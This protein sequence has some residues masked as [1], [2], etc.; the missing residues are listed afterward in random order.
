MRKIIRQ[1]LFGASL[2]SFGLG[3]ST[4]M[5]SSAP[6]LADQ[7]RNGRYRQT[8]LVSDQ[9][10][11][12]LLQDTNLVN[13]W[14]VSFGPSSPF[15]VSDNGTGLST[16]YIVT[17]D[18][19]GMTH[20]IK[21]PLQVRIPGEGTPTGQLFNGNTNSFHGNLFIFASEDGIISG[22]RPQ[23][24]T[25]AEVLVARS[26]AVYKGITMAAG[27]HG[28]VLLAANF[29]EA[30]IDEYDANLHLIGQFS[31]SM[32]PADYGPFNVQNLHG[33]VFVTY[34][35]QDAD[36]QDDVAGPGNGLIDVFDPGT[37]M[38]DRFATGL[39]AGGN[40]R[41]INSPWGLALAPSTFGDHADELLVGNFGSGT[42]MTFEADGRFQGLLRGE[43][44]RPVVIDGLWAL[45]FGNGTQAGSPDT[46]FFSAGPDDESHGLFGEL[47]PMNDH[48]AAPQD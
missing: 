12:A 32:A 46:L 47:Q 24:G 28:P 15:W 4:I 9:P 16:L 3:I 34:A 30:T 36:K 10:G 6:T 11:V 31:D 1:R 19:S 29:K 20:V 35:K 26:T 48:P 33:V 23:L 37:H 17:N 21:R 22:W 38:F 13:A 25:T 2:F 27:D 44:Y 40:L 45:T 18:S 42:I 41:A 43:N 7:S 39:D 5:L 8:N 14:G